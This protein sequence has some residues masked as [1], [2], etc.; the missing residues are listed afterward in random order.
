MS[1]NCYCDYDTPEL[2]IKEIRTARKQHRC[3]ECRGTI[4]P[5][6][7]YEHVRGKW[8]GEMGSF[9]TCQHCIDLRTWTKNNVPC[10]CWAHGSIQ[11]DCR[12]AIEDA[13]YRAPRETAGLMFGFL[14]RI[15]KRDR[16]N[17]QRR[18]L[19]VAA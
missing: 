3:Y 11:D 14:R 2:Y 7:K 13:R 8:E 1:T 6:E 18:A 10:L 5:G 16:I 12:E 17:K 9:K 4:L 19:A 15:V